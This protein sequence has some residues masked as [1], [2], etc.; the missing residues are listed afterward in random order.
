M[1]SWPN[2]GTSRWNC[3]EVLPTSQNEQLPLLMCFILWRVSCPEGFKW[4]DK[5]IRRCRTYQMHRH[6]KKD[7]DVVISSCI[8]LDAMMWHHL[9]QTCL[10]L[11]KQSKKQNNPLSCMGGTSFWFPPHLLEYCYFTVG[12]ICFC[13]ESQSFFTLLMT[14]SV[15]FPSPCNISL[16][17]QLCKTISYL[18]CYQKLC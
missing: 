16:S 15:P 11:L 3:L 1:G 9:K 7:I 8:T 2:L 13:T 17:K 18:A 14:A 5:V 10:A 12:G 4:A 6:S